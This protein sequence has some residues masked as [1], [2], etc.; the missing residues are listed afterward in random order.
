[1]TSPHEWG[2]PYVVS[3]YF[4]SGPRHELRFCSARLMDM[5]AEAMKRKQRPLVIARA[6]EYEEDETWV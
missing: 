1:M 6:Y 4:E 3:W 2:E 5:F